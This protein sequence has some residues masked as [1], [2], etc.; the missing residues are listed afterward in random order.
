MGLVTL[1]RYIIGMVVPL[2][3]TNLAKNHEVWVSGNISTHFQKFVT[4]RE[5]KWIIFTYAAGQ[6]DCR[7]EL[8]EQM[9]IGHKLLLF[10]VDLCLSEISS[11]ETMKQTSTTASGSYSWI[12]FNKS[13][14]IKGGWVV[15]REEAATKRWKRREASIRRKGIWEGRKHSS[16]P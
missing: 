16:Q 6:R 10:L 4:N 1:L 7:D 2:L 14:C 3:E 8:D 11:P 5:K 9:Y 13:K 12:Y 15:L